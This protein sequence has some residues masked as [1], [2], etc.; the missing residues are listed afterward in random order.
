MNSRLHTKL[1]KLEQQAAPLI[2]RIQRRKAIIEE[3]RVSIQDDLEGVLAVARYCSLRDDREQLELSMIEKVFM[4]EYELGDDIPTDAN[5]RAAIRRAD[6][7]LELEYYNRETSIDELMEDDRLA[8]QVRADMKAGIP[9]EQSEA[10]R[11]IREEAYAS[12]PPLRK[13]SRLLT[14]Y[15]AGEPMPDWMQ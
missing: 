11:L 6:Q 9:A 13:Q 4:M 10:A 12:P 7:R 14:A 5:I 15:L 1:D 3:I 8:V 2:E